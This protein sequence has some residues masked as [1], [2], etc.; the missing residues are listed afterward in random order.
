MKNLHRIYSSH[1]LSFRMIICCFLSWLMI[2]SLTSF[3]SI[4]EV[5]ICWDYWLCVCT[6]NTNLFLPDRKSLLHFSFFFGNC[7]D[8]SFLHKIVLVSVAVYN[9]C[10]QLAR[11]VL[12]VGRVEW[13]EW[14][15]LSKTR[16]EWNKC[17]NSSKTQVEWD[18]C[19]NSFKTQVEWNKWMNSSSEDGK[20]I[21]TLDTGLCF[22]ATIIKR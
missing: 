19:M 20:C 15:Y 8:L 22:Q 6:V 12:C 17:M 5:K 9:F 2:S 4:R 11:K 16:V 7:L 1:D 18:K 13:N 10:V 3:I 21:S 14:M